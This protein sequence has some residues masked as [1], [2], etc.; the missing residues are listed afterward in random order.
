METKYA[1]IVVETSVV[2]VMMA[3]KLLIVLDFTVGRDH[4]VPAEQ[5]VISVEPPCKSLATIVIAVPGVLIDRVH[6]G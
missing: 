6:R 4:T 3:R 5:G 2:I 1:Q